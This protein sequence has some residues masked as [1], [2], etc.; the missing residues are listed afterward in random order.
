MKPN[1]LPQQDLTATDR[2]EGSLLGEIESLLRSCSETPYLD[3]LVL[4]GQITGRSK[5]DL[6]THPSPLLSPDQELQL[7]AALDRLLSGT[8]LPYVLGKWEFFK[9]SFRLTSDTLIPRP[10]TEGL[11]ERALAWLGDHPERRSCLEPG[12]G[13]GCI[14][15][16]LGVNVPDLRITATDLSLGALLTARENARDH[17]VADRIDF[18]QARYHY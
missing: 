13:S 2:G 17:G 8:P 12:T 4:L 18:L 6:L 7:A 15:V 3:A 1:A 16:S 9:L 5:S 11:V 14:G 10:E